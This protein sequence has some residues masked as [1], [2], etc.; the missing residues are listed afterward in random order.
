MTKPLLLSI[1]KT[2]A[3]MDEALNAHFSTTYL[4]QLPD[5]DAWL[6]IHGADVTYVLTD[7]HLGLPP[8]ILTKLPKL[9]AVSCYGVGYDAIDTAATNARGV[10][11]S[12]TP[13]VLNKD[14]A[15]L[16]VLLF[17]ACYRNFTAEA[18]HAKSGAWEVLGEL[19]LSRSPENK[20]IGIAGLGRIGLEVARKLSVFS[21]EISYH[22]RTPRA[23]VAYPY[24][25]DLTEMAHHVDALISVLPGGNATHHIINQQ[26]IEAL[27]PEGVFVNIGRG[28][29]VDEA[30]LITALENGKLGRAGLDVFDSEPHIPRA[31]REHKNAIL[32]PHVASATVET[33]RAMGALA[34][35]NL[36]SHLQT[37]EMLTLVPECATARAA[38]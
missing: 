26:V 24:F 31:L 27:G 17:L 28:S 12:H 18:H 10:Q 37:D 19:P 38:G 23:D 30:A 15:N 14:V 5:P 20:K 11:V 13:D 9:K 34:I 1:C 2:T 16:A 25:Q 32:T 7:G 21:A 22:S 29:V 8:P 6:A 33:R 35:D 3:E 36:V 4:Q